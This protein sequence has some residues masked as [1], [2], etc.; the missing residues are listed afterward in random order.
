[1]AKS[2]AP[3]GE[4]ATMGEAVQKLNWFHAAYYE[5]VRGQTGQSQDA[6]TGLVWLGA[7]TAG[8]AAGQAHRDAIFGTSLLGGT[9]YGLARTQLDARRIDIWVSGMD[10]LDCAKAAAAP[11]DIGTERVGA[12]EDARKGLVE[13]RAEA[14][15]SIDTAKVVL[16]EFA[17]T[18]TDKSAA[19][20]IAIT[21]AQEAVADVDK[22]LAAAIGLLDA[23]R[24]KELSITVDRIHTG[25]TTAMKDLAVDP[26]S[27]K[28]LISGAG[29]FGEIFAPGAGIGASF[30]GAFA[31][32]QSASATPAANANMPVAAML[33]EKNLNI[34]FGS[35][36]KSQ[37]PNPPVQP[38]LP[39]DEIEKAMKALEASIGAM[40]KAQTRVNSLLMNV[41]LD[42]VSLS[43]KRCGVTGASTA[44][45]LEPASLTFTSGTAASKGFMISGGTPP[46]VVT[47][48]DELP[49]GL[50]PE[51]K[52]GLSDSV[53]VKITAS[54]VSTGTYQLLISDSGSSKRTKQLSV[55][56]QAAAK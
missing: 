8:L 6:T 2:P 17:K 39:T 55:T 32:Y 19:A 40:G 7:I 50:S 10:A 1:M 33:V 18:P 20:Q 42:Q 25:V 4:P 28:Q 27:I 34:A 12:L 56:V 47:A 26:R 38:A 29:S 16:D 52:G 15:R 22:T 54:A 31:K 23:T 9:T 13:R 3:A 24:G 49:T 44:L 35:K 30:T 43:L 45:V 48:L 37:A 21:K 36:G 5:A 14:Q 11:L 51:F 46:Y 53:L 41:N